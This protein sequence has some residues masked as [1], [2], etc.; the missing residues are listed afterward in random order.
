MLTLT[1]VHHGD[2]PLTWLQ[3]RIWKSFKLMRR[4]KHF[5]AN[6]SGGVA[7]QENKWSQRTGGWHVHL[8]ILIQGRYWDQKQISQLWHSCT[9]DSFIVDIQSKFSSERMAHYASKYVTKPIDFNSVVGTPAL[10][11]AIRATK[12]KHMYLIFGDWKG[13]LQLERKQPLDSNW[14]IVGNANDLWMDAANGDI[15]ASLVI[16]Q[17][18]TIHS[19][20]MPQ[21]HD[22]P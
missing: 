11:E 18:T 9:G 17:L 1:L 14:D 5:R 21:E 20:N 12:G 2:E 13:K 8:H 19:P 15:N 22:P 4:S 10:T 3:D 7:F 6:V 16:A